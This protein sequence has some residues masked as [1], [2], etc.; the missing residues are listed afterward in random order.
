[1]GTRQTVRRH[2]REL[3]LVLLAVSGILPQ[4]LFKQRVRVDVNVHV[5]VDVEG[6]VDQVLPPPV[7]IPQLNVDNE[8]L[9]FQHYYEVLDRTYLDCAHQPRGNTFWTTSWED[10][11][12]KCIGSTQCLA[13]SR[14][15]LTGWTTLCDGGSWKRKPVRSLNLCTIVDA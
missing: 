1:M 5:K 13:F 2:C 4:I 11:I 7:P 10:A 8:E 9:F 6:D 3:I 12:K 15:T 14:N